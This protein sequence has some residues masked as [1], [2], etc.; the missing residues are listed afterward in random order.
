MLRRKGVTGLNIQ[1]YAEEGIGSEGPMCLEDP[2]SLGNVAHAGVT[3]MEKQQG[4]VD[5]TLS[6]AVG[7]TK[8]TPWWEA[9]SRVGEIPLV[10]IPTP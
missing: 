7:R 10:I 5:R 9:W 3:D 2:T 1:G 6:R 8:W 4:P